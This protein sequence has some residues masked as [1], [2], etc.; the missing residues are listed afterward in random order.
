MQ[1]PRVRGRVQYTGGVRPRVYVYSPRVYVYSPRVYVYSPRVYVY[2]PRVY[3]YS[4]RVYGARRGDWRTGPTGALRYT[5]YIIYKS[6]GVRDWRTGGA[7]RL[8]SESPV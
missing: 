3:V 2:S 4:P 6:I 5:S 1:S 8:P 7:S